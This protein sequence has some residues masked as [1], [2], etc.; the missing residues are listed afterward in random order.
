MSRN[1]KNKNNRT[2]PM[3]VLKIEGTKALLRDKSG[4]KFWAELRHTYKLKNSWLKEN[5]LSYKEKEI[6]VIERLVIKVT[7]SRKIINNKSL[8]TKKYKYEKNICVV[9]SENKAKSFGVSVGTKYHWLAFG[10]YPNVG[11]YI[12]TALTSNS[13]S[14]KVGKVTKVDKKKRVCFVSNIPIPVWEISYKIIDKNFTVTSPVR[15]N[16]PF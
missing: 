6:N 12:M 7:S 13:F 8:S 16:F 5:K 4:D 10:E 2:V 15:D 3:N 14:G 1:R 9:D 11:D